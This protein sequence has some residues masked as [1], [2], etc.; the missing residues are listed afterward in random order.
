MTV[1][2]TIPCGYGTLRVPRAAETFS[3]RVGVGR[4]GDRN[5]SLRRGRMTKKNLWT[6]SM[7]SRKWSTAAEEAKE[8]LVYDRRT[9]MNL[10]GWMQVKW[11]Y[12]YD[13]I[14]GAD[15]ASGAG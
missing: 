6:L 11:V 7:P 13:R 5:G 15:G 8:R 1:Y 14:G 3:V 12:V 4:D 9:W 10:C 2:G